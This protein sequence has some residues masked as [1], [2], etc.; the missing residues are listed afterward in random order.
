VDVF[1]TRLDA[2][3][4]A[5][6]LERVE[7]FV[8]QALAG[9]PNAPPVNVVGSPADIGIDAPQ[10]VPTGVTLRSG[11]I[12]VFQTG[13]DSGLDVFKTVFHELFHKGLSVTLPRQGY[14]RVMLDLAKRDARVKKHADAWRKT[15][16][17][18]DQRAALIAVGFSGSA[19]NG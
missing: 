5:L 17:A 2:P 4:A 10:E 18:Q 3:K 19:L 9:V 14:V 12:Y 13:I 6:S 7:Q 8:K 1:G 16:I 11:E 15:G